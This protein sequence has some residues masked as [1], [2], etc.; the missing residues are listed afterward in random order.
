MGVNMKKELEKLT[1]KI[2]F[3]TYK[4]I[5]N[6]IGSS[7]FGIFLG[8]RLI[9]SGNPNLLVDL[10]SLALVFINTNMSLSDSRFATKDMLEIKKLYQEFIQNYNKLNK[11]FDLK[12]PIE[13]AAM[14][15]YLLNGGYLSLNHSF[16]FGKSNVRNIISLAGINVLAGEGVCRH[17]TGLLND[18]LNDYGIKAKMLNGYIETIKI[19]IRELPR[20]KYTKEELYAWIEKYVPEEEAKNKLYERVADSD[21]LE[22][23]L[24][25]DELLFR[26]LWNHAITYTFYEGHNI[27][28]DATN[29]WIFNLSTNT[30]NLLYSVSGERM[31]IK[32]FGSLLLSNA[33]IG[34]YLD[35]KRDLKAYPCLDLEEEQKMAAN[36]K[37]ICRNNEDIFE[38]FYQENQGLIGDV[39][40]LTLNLKKRLSY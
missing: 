13:I 31:F 26:L 14:Y 21:K 25:Q 10:F 12:N 9:N 22:F 24:I 2:D 27:F 16:I 15:N 20:A 18:I 37:A 23:K 11:V 36:T 17:I 39:A 40:N 4:A 28:L 32:P 1:G 6:L 19:M 7:G 38:E 33:T 29:D 35:L 3:D 5:E 8:N 30:F 34:S